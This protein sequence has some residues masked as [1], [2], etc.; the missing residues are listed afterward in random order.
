MGE[1]VQDR[2]LH[3][4]ADHPAISTQVHPVLVTKDE[5][6]EK[7]D[8]KMDKLITAVKAMTDRFDG[9]NRTQGPNVQFGDPT[10]VDECRYCKILLS[11]NSGTIEES[12]VYAEL[13]HKKFDDIHKTWLFERFNKYMLS[14][15]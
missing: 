8:E 9:R 7:E 1:R 10:P 3:M 12:T 5:R 6:A 4:N 14:A 11:D 15:N 13:K 2:L